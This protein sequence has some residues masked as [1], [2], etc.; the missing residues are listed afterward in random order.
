MRLSMLIVLFA[1]TAAFGTPHVANGPEPAE[2]VVDLRLEPVW[3]VGGEDDEET[4]L[5]L[6]TQIIEDADG[7]LYLLDRQLSQVSV[8][9]PDGEFLR[10]LSREGDGPGE[11]RGPNDM[12]FTPEGDLALMQIFPGRVVLIDTMGEPRGTFPYAT[13]GSSFAVLVRGVSS[14][15]T[16]ALAGIN[17]NFAGG[18]LTQ[19]YFLSSFAADGSVATTFVE[20]ANT[21]N[22]GAMV[23]DERSVD[24]PWSRFDI[25]ASGRLIVAPSRD[26]YLIEVRNPDGTLA[27]SFDRELEPWARTETD[28]R[29]IHQALEAQGRN[30]PA[31]PEITYEDTEPALNSLT[32]L[33][34]GSIWT[35][36]NRSLRSRAPGVAIEWDVFSA[37][38]GYLR[39]VRLL[40]DADGLDDLIRIL[41]PDRAIVVRNFWSALASSRGV[42]NDGDE[43]PSPMSVISCRLVP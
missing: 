35:V 18:Q 39:R 6:I 42:E 43:D 37:E 20:K 21:M 19:A 12:F 29:R 7:N 1:A 4:I 13:D 17:Q 15:G 33:E 8:F 30:Y 26:D 25:D 28:E 31:P 5:G 38:G 14:G 16:L 22:F 10:A 41:S 40:C 27:L 34:D 9:S 3:E 23:L 2:G 36:T 24:F 11:V 32:V